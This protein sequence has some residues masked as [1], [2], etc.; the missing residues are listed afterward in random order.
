MMMRARVGAHEHL[1]LK[2]IGRLKMVTDILGL[3][4]MVCLIYN[5][6]ICFEW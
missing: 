2:M 1:P 5:V 4:S 3:M 6:T